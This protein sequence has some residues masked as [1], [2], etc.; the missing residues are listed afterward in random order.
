MD[1]NDRATGTV[2]VR[3]AVVA[4]AYRQYL[5]LVL[6]E[7]AVRAVLTWGITDRYT[8]LNSEGPRE[9]G[10]AKR[11]LP[12]DGEY[13]ATTAFFAVRGAFDGRVPQKA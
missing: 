13:R 6:K 12:F 4:E 9:D 1:V 3:D 7:P 2:E 8:W 10:L 11:P 5:E